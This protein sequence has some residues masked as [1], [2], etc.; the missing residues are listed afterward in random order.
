MLHYLKGGEAVQLSANKHNREQE[1]P[2]KSKTCLHCSEMTLR[3]FDIPVLSFF[4]FIIGHAAEVMIE[5]H[6]VSS[7]HACRS[8]PQHAVTEC[9]EADG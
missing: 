3:N 9:G 8:M 4:V 1:E 2:Q 7:E 5:Q 6:V